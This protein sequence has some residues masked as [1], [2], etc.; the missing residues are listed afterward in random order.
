MSNS[1]FIS[2]P[3]SMQRAPLVNPVE[4]Q[5]S[6]LDRQ[7]EKGE[8]WA[9]NRWNI[10]FLT[11][12]FNENP[13]NIRQIISLL[14][15]MPARERVWPKASWMT[16]IPSWMLYEMVDAQYP[17][18]EHMRQVKYPTHYAATKHPP[19]P[20]QENLLTPLRRKASSFSRNDLLRLNHAIR[21]Y[22]KDDDSELRDIHDPDLVND[23]IVNQI[24]DK[25][26][27]KIPANNLDDQKS[28]VKDHF[29][30][31]DTIDILPP[32]IKS[33]GARARLTFDR[34]NPAVYCI[35]YANLLLVKNNKPWFQLPHD[36]DREID[37]LLKGK[38]REYAALNL[39][40]VAHWKYPRKIVDINDS[41]LCRL[42]RIAPGTLARWDRG[43]RAPRNI[44]IFFELFAQFPNETLDML[45]RVQ[46]EIRDSLLTKLKTTFPGIL[47]E[48]PSPQSTCARQAQS[49][50]PATA[51]DKPKAAPQRKPRRY[52]GRICGP[53]RGTPDS[54]GAYHL[55]QPEIT[56]VS[57]VNIDEF[58][59]SSSRL[60]DL[61]HLMRKYPSLTREEM[62]DMEAIAKLRLPHLV[63]RKVQR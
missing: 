27:T 6:T 22:F 10:P 38:N 53:S 32:D 23:P 41:L 40:R 29:N 18:E 36:S 14:N 54:S 63:Q 60:I 58:K 2:L 31:Y 51:P 37:M 47:I 34:V 12:L 26:K 48:Y 56:S 5:K 15:A 20:K 44:R 30:E 16:G 25:I 24:V 62:H 28:R 55:V 39:P 19:P 42:L 9:K 49:G 46:N 45:L 13:I 35:L 17:D 61:A 11:R 59:K 57:G 1:K 21:E 52:R 50:P 8:I 33:R 43:Y 4:E 3:L 7:E